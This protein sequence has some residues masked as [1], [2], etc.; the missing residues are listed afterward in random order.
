VKLEFVAQVIREK[1][2]EKTILWIESNPGKKP[3][4]KTIL[5]IESNPGKKPFNFKIHWETWGKF[6]AWIVLHK[7]L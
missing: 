2:W 5:W 7:K 4:K 3:F 1:T 6:F